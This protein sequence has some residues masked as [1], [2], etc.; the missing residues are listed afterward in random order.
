[1]KTTVTAIKANQAIASQNTFLASIKV[2]DNLAVL[3]DQAKSLIKVLVK[4]ENYGELP[5]PVLGNMLDMLEEKLQAM[6][7]NL[8]NLDSG[9]GVMQ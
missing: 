6:E 5:S 1:M 7:A 3:L 4:D 8:A 9:V 2:T